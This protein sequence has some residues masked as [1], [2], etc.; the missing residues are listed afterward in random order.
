MKFSSLL[1]R[2]FAR[3]ALPLVLL[4]CSGTF[5]FGDTIN[6][7]GGTGGTSSD[8][9]GLTGGSGSQYQ[10]FF[11]NSDDGNGT[12]EFSSFGTSPGTFLFTPNSM[13]SFNGNSVFTILSANVN[14][15]QQL[16][17][18][19]SPSTTVTTFAVRPITAS[20]EPGTI[21]L[22]VTGLAAVALIRHRR[23]RV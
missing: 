21:F 8:D 10:G 9:V 5:L 7:I 12:P 23:P 4:A 6:A 13:F 22:V 17:P 18:I 15:G 3:S 16:I 11:S 20:P 2:G 14:P 19:S 1:V